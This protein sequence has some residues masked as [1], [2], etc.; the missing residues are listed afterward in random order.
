MKHYSQLLRLLLV[1]LS[2]CAFSAVI[3]AQEV[4]GS[5]NGT[6]K[7]A[8]GGVVSGATVT[9]SDSEK[10]VVLRTTTTNNDGQYS[11]PNI[12]SGV[13]DVTV[14][15]PNFKKHVDTGLKLNVSDKR[16]VDVTL[17]AGNISE[18]VTVEA[19]PLAVQLNTPTAVSIISGDQVREL[20]LNNRNWVQLVALSPGVSNDLADQVYVGTTNPAGQ[21]N[22]INVSVNG[23]RSAQNTF[24]VDG[25]DITDRGSNITIQAY[26][27]VDSIGEFRVLRSL[28]PAETGNSGG[29]QV[30]VITR[31][32]GDSFHGS[33][34]EF[35]RNERLNAN[36]FIS[37]SLSNPPFGR[38]SNGKA[39]RS[40]FRYNNFG[41]TIG[42]PIYIP[43]FGE[44]RGGMF[45]KLKRTFFFFSEERR[46]DIR[47]PALSATVPDAALRQGIFPVDVCIN[48]ND[49][50]G[51]TCTGANILPR[52]SALNPALFNPAA[53]AYLN[54]IY[55]R[56][57]LPNAPN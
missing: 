39:K 17:E 38:D 15:A 26:P 40:P 56:L 8:T 54:Q 36:D 50:V 32:G 46:K 44:G 42:G 49:I 11:A 28:Y 21:A 19:A 41:G 45:S 13:Y 52:G 29:G 57:P 18:V 9:I 24:R 6:V 22:T 51:A 16:A 14:E 25:A 20:S 4:T 1:A 47:Y 30:N 34:F 33:L 43:N 3:F 10:K 7:D 2:I 35:V 48:R 31:S 37:N 5:L 23:A 12:P 55:N 27:S 53:L